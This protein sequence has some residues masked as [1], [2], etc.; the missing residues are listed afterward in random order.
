MKAKT[1]NGKKRSNA[2]VQRKLKTALTVTTTVMAMMMMI[3]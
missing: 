3:H 1:A 2:C